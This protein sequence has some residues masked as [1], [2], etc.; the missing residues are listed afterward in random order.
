MRKFSVEGIS[1][2]ELLITLI[3]PLSLLTVLFAVISYYLKG[4]SFFTNL[5]TEF[6]SIV[7]T[8]TYVNWVFKQ[9]KVKKWEEPNRRIS[10]RLEIITN[11]FITTLRTSFRFDFVIFDE[12][13]SKGE[14]L[15]SMHL[16]LLK[17][18]I[19]V[20]TPIIFNKLLNLDAE[21]WKFLI[22]EL[23]EILEKIDSVFMIYGN[24]LGPEKY[25]LLL[26]IQEELE[27]I[28]KEYKAIPGIF[29]QPN[30]SREF[31][32]YIK[33]NIADRITLILNL[34]MELNKLK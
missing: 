6:I 11:T 3:L 30:P 13:T 33:A 7:V 24:N 2:R 4:D 14:D 20:L 10:G 15:S 25:L 21:R 18:S 23:N 26:D 32:K 1:K 29:E 22:S 28:I 8:V 17:V 5:T 9:H 27:D 31:D 12:N 16:K 34:L 19:E